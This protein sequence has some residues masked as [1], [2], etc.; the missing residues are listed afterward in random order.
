MGHRILR[1]VH[2]LLRSDP[3]VRRE[4][5]ERFGTKVIGTDGADREAIARIVFNDAEA[6]DRLKS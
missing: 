2:R 4:L 3:D 1:I 6:V 5:V